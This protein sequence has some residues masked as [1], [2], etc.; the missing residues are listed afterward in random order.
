LFFS[1][2]SFIYKPRR[3]IEARVISE[4]KK[5][6]Y[7][8]LKLKNR[9]V[10]FYTT[11][12]EDLK[13]L[14]NDRVRLKIFTKNISFFGYLT[15]FYAPSYDIK[16][17]PL[18]KADKFIETQHKERKISNLFRALFLG[19]S[20][21]YQTRLALSALGIA[22][23]FAL[24][25]LHLGIIS[26][27]VFFIVKLFY[28]LFHRYFPYRNLYFDVGLIVL[29]VEFLYLYFTNFPPSLIRA[30]LL[31]VIL[32]FIFFTLRDVLRFRVLGLL[33]GVSVLFF[34][35][36]V[37]TLGFLL[38][39]LGVFYIYLFFNYFKPSFKN[40]I[41]LSFYLF[42]VMSVY[43]FYFFHKSSDFI[44]LSPLISLLFPFFY[45]VELV[46][47]LFNLGGSLDFLVKGI[48]NLGEVRG[49]DVRV[50]E[51]FGFFV[52]SLLAI[53]KKWAFYGIN[54]LGLIFVLRSFL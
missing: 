32:F 50:V 35:F 10:T 54:V 19:E 38:S 39:F 11:T 13:N 5:R 7:Y 52:F 16:L 26:F 51:V 17:L 37:F 40:S 27:L 12:Y 28:S 29:A 4:Y 23:L 20:M 31:E 30:Y 53:K 14:I 21:D 24:S 34:T 6:D 1:Y 9:E 3:V 2:L 42:V 36:S 43:S 18:S 41:L 15:T 49:V 25:G 45:V 47:H 44:F 8:V 46:L 48:L 22:H 33:F